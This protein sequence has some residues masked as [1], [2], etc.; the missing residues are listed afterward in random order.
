MTLEHFIRNNRGINDNEDFPPEFLEELYNSIA[1][2][3]FRIPPPPQDLMGSNASTRK[4]PS[5]PTATQKALLQKKQGYVGSLMLVLCQSSQAI[6]PNANHLIH[7]WQ[8]SCP[9]CLIPAMAQP[10]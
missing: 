5:R 10:A 3:G 7:W 1:C 6:C 8:H 4:A 2:K 9:L